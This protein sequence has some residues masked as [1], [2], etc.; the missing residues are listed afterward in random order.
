MAKSIDDVLAMLDSVPGVRE[1]M[2]SFPVRMGRAIRYRRMELGWRQEELAQEIERL[3]GQPFDPELIPQ[4]EGG[5]DMSISTYERVF[6]A[7][8]MQGLEFKW[9]PAKVMGELE[10]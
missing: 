9:Q 10:K 6:F 2:N 7:L 5:T 4:I 8:G 3:T 1:F